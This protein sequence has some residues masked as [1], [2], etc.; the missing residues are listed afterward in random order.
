MVGRN[1]SGYVALLTVLMTGAIATAIALALLVSGV[2]SQ[3]SALIG[4]QSKQ[5][6]ALAV[7]C[8]EEALQQVHDNIAFAGTNTLNLGQGGCTYIVLVTAPTTRSIAVTANVGNVARKIQ[9]YATIGVS[10][11]SITSWQDVM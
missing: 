2:D 11:I 9:T 1:E 7:A 4:Q 6:R 10:N 5:A 8:A 3:R